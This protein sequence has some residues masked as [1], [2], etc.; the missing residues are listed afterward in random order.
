MAVLTGDTGKVAVGPLKTYSFALA[1]PRESLNAT[2]MALPSTEPASAQ[3]SVTIQESDLPIITPD[4]LGVTYTASLYAAGKNTDAA[5]Q[6]VSWRVLKNGTS[7]ATGTSTSVPAN[8]F[9]THGYFQFLGVVVGDVLDVKLW[10][11]SANVNYDYYAIAVYP[12]RANLSKEA[13]VKDVTYGAIAAS[14]LTAGT[15]SSNL[16]QSITI[17]PSESNTLSMGNAANLMFGALHW[18]SLYNAFRIDLGDNQIVTQTLAHATS[19]PH[20]RRNVLTSTISFRE[21]LR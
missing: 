14:T 5:A 21:V 3:I 9:W 7:V 10:S 19:R 18:N 8:Q 17:Y 20:Y 16:S 11:A 2:P 4:P 1:T 15:A 6:T 12:T 13:I